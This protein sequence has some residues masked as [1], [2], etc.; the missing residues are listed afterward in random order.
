MYAS[1]PLLHLLYHD[2]FVRGTHHEYITTK[3]RKCGTGHE[4]QVMLS[5]LFS[6]WGNY[7]AGYVVFARPRFPVKAAAGGFFFPWKIAQE[8]PDAHV[9]WR[10]GRATCCIKSGG[11]RGGGV[12]VGLVMRYD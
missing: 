11:M 12:G 8:H 9:R 2:S 6:E 5:A 7:S 4:A 3:S 1:A 10:G